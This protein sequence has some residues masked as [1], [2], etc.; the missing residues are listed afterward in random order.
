MR[1]DR[2][3]VGLG[4]AAAGAV[5]AATLVTVEGNSSAE[6][7]AHR[8]VS[9]YIEQ[10]DGVQQQLRLRLTDMSS[11]Y[12]SFASGKPGPRVMHQVEAAEAALAAMQVRVRALRPPTEAARLHRL[13]LQLLRADR[14]V[15]HELSML[16]AFTPRFRVVFASA[17]AAGHEL[18]AS[19]AVARVPRPHTVKGTPR[20]IAKARAAYRAAALAAATAQ[21]RAVAVYDA[22]LATVLAKLRALRAPPVMATMLRSEIAAL[23][24]TR[25]A[26][27]ALA[28][29][30][31]KTN[32]T[33]V[34][35]LSR[36]FSLAARTAA[37]VAA[38]RAQVA[39]IKA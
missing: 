6:S 8:A 7:P 19:L 24:A 18:A 28:G 31:R 11:A 29:E 32:L 36:Q 23:V 39:A 12:R 5:A 9:A 15:A 17:A 1:L 35:L 20:Q 26:G 25:R 38:Q 4:V 33:R 27:A 3:T 14:G 2:R 34:P 30:L 21:S 13:I 22:R 10:V 37:S 16:A